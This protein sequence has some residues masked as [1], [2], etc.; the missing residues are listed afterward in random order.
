MSA[1]AC[2]NR[3]G[4]TVSGRDEE[5]LAPEVVRA[6]EIRGT[7]YIVNFLHCDQG[8]YIFDSS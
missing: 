6:K 1:D 7:A 8:W 3:D 2:N 5:R 4:D